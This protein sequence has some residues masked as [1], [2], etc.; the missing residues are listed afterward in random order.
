MRAPIDDAVALITGAS[1]GI[2][3]AIARELAPRAKTLILV[4]RRKPRLVA[5]ADELREAFRGLTVDV[6][7]CDLTDRDGLSDMCDAV[8]EEHGCVDILVNNAGLGDIGVFDW[9]PWDKT[10]RMLELNVR[11][12]TYLTHR[13]LKPMVAQKR[14]GILMMSSGFGL[15]FAP[16]F[17]GYV[18]TKHYVTGFCE[19][20]RLELR[21][22]GVVVTQVC[23]GPVATEFEEIAGN[24]TGV[25]P[26]PIQ[27][28]AERCARVAVRG[29]SRG[30]AMV[31]PGAIATVLMWMAAI[32]PR[33]VLRLVYAP[34]G[35]LF[36][37][38]QAKARKLESGGTG[39]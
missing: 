17:A 34:I 32:T 10:E 26:G 21:H 35:K 2:G 31:I 9:A 1:S 24:F 37:E 4:A 28:S 15:S 25:S 19:S 27:I 38:R 7:T 33:W 6:R 8:E 18:A 23:P 36:R 30:R 13:L 14:G 3:A 11:A 20:L 12:L 16:G 39:L 5:L 29:F 22:L